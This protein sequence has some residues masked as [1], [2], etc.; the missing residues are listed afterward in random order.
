MDDYSELGGLLIREYK[1]KTMKLRKLK[2]TTEKD[3]IISK[4]RVKSIFNLD[5]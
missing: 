3:G 5:M 1:C 4:N 2:C